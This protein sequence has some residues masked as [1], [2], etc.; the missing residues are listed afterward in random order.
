MPARSEVL[1]NGSIRRQK[2]LGMT[3]RLKSLPNMQ[4]VQKQV[5]TPRPTSNLLSMAGVF[6]GDKDIARDK[7]QYTY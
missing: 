2:A 3:R 5:R 1:G 4:E 6:K 7:K